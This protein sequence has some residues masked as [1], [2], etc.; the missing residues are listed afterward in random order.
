MSHDRWNQDRLKDKIPSSYN[1]LNPSRPSG[2]W[3]HECAG[4]EIL[5]C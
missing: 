2:S 1:F 4:I 5:L 3:K